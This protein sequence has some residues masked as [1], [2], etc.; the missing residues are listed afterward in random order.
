[1]LLILLVLA[2]LSV[3]PA[4]P[5][6]IGWGYVTSGLVGLLVLA[7]AVMLVTGI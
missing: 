7:L 2:L 6:S 3:I 1:V 4:W 5:H